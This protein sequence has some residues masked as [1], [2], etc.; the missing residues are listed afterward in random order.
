MNITKFGEIGKTKKR[1]VLCG[2]EHKKN[3]HPRVEEKAE[4]FGGFKA[5]SIIIKLNN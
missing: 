5:N 1:V 3:C 2:P 4:L